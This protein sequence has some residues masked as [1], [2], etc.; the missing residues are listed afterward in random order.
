MNML[1]KFFSGSEKFI[2]SFILLFSLPCFIL[3]LGR[4]QISESSDSKSFGWTDIDKDQELQSR[5]IL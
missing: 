3:C 2:P 5:E 4:M 1:A